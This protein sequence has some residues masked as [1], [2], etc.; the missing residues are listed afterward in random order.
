MEQ[1]LKELYWTNLKSLSQSLNLPLVW[2]TKSD[3][4]EIQCVD[5]FVTYKSII[6]Y[7]DVPVASVNA[8]YSQEQNDIDKDDFETNY[9]E[10]LSSNLIVT[11]QRQEPANTFGMQMVA[12]C[13]TIPH[14]ESLEI[15]LPIQN[16]A[17]ES[18]TFK[19]IWGGQAI[20]KDASYGDWATFQIVDKDNILGYGTG[21]ILKE[22][23]KKCY[24]DPN[25]RLEFESLA[26]GK[27]L[28]GLY[29]RC[30]YTSVGSI[31]PTIYINYDVE[32]RD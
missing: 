13:A 10:A 3:R 19:Y 8:G 7:R 15:D 30:I 22:Y 5:Q 18:Y 1:F 12:I 28:V 31:D 32:T 16:F 25:R 11:Q 6:W 21:V 14:G 17:N 9:K 4:Y 23:I 26:P 29:L 27:L 2:E 20:L 24:M